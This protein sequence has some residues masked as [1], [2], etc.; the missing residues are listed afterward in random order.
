MAAHTSTSLQSLWRALS[1]PL[2]PTWP[3]LLGSRALM[4]AGSGVMLIGSMVSAHFTKESEMHRSVVMRRSRFAEPRRA[5]RWWRRL[6]HGYS[7]RQ[8]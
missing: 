2:A 6:L 5:L 4:G 1:S 3:M 8:C 7:L